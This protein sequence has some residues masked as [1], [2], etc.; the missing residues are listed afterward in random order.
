[1]NQQHALVAYKATGILGSKRREM[2][3]RAREVIVYLSSAPMSP[4]LEYSSKSGALT[5]GKMWSFW[6]GSRGGP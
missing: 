2:A 1:V 6:R 5:T 4:Q 3:S